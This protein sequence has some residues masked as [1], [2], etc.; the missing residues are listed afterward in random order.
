MP[1]VV[2]LAIAIVGIAFGVGCPLWARRRVAQERDRADRAWVKLLGLRKEPLR[3]LIGIHLGKAVE[4]NGDLFGR[5]VAFAARV[6][7][8]GEEHELFEVK[9]S[10]AP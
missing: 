2:S 7:A 5:N 9:W 3:V 4:K 8:A 6:A 1:D 10:E